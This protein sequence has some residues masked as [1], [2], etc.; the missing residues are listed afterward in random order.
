M[1]SIK[2]NLGLECFLSYGCLLGAVRNGQL[3]PHD[4]DID[5]GFIAQGHSEKDISAASRILTQFLIDRGFKIDAESNGQFKASYQESGS[6]FTVEFFVTWVDGSDFYHYFGVRGDSIADQIIPLAEISLEGVMLPSPKNPERLLEAI[7]GSNWRTPDPGFRYE[8]TAKDW[9][10]FKFLFARNNKKFWDDY[11]SGRDT[12]RVWVNVP[13]QFAAFVATNIDHGN[14]ILDV[15]CGNGRDGVFFASAGFQP[16]LADFSQ[17]ALD[18]ASNLGVTAG[19]QVPIHLLNLT[20]LADVHRFS[21]RFRAEFD[22]VYARFLL[23]AITDI[24]EDSLLELSFD[25]LKNGGRL[26]L[27]Y[28]C[29][30]A[31]VKNETV[32]YENGKHYRRLINQDDLHS[33]ARKIGFAVEYSVLGFGYAKFRNEDPLI[34]RTVLFK[35]DNSTETK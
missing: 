5:V 1:Q 4:F 30:E 12:N 8:L 16:M 23:H 18:A 33:A 6:H 28:R 10:P 7:Y 3:I 32:H 14:K 21:N 25:V 19:H 22:N 13:S 2:D 9:V 15:G 29:A 24:G 11:Y 31:G 26:M 34:G 35:S 27:E 20:D 17:A